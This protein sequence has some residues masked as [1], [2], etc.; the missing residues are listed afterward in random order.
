MTGQVAGGRH[1][2]AAGDVEVEAG[3]LELGEVDAAEVEAERFVRRFGEV[4]AAPSPERLNSLVHPDAV[5]VQP[6]EREV[7]GHAEAAAFWR[8]LFRLVPDLRGEIV[9]W[10]HR[11][12]VVYI[13]VRLT[14]TLGGRPIE[15][16]SLD[17][18]QL[19]AGKV[20]HRG[21]NFDPLPL[22][23]AIALR[24]KALALFLLTR[25]RR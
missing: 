3:G 11:G 17:R 12:A 24:P 19:D 15:W 18:I 16:T 21:A 4:W 23:G 7:H 9:S 25:V 1:G 2:G 10:G 13:E 6:I 5:F 14:G 20:R 8:R 22:I